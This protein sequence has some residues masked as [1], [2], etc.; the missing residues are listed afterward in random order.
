MEH[1][2]VKIGKKSIEAFCIRLMDRNFVLL[3]GS[4]GYVMCGYLNLTIAEK[5]HDVAVKIVGV[6]TIDWALPGGRK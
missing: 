6:S 3:R 4:K 5:F 1:K 2:K